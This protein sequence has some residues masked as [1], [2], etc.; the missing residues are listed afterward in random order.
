M[1]DT[2]L[3]PLPKMDRAIGRL[4]GEHTRWAIY[5]HDEKVEGSDDERVKCLN[6]SVKYR[7]KLFAAIEKWATS[8]VLADRREL[9]RECDDADK[10][11]RTIGLDPDACRTDG[12]SLNLPRILRLL[13]RD[14]L[15]DDQRMA[16]IEAWSSKGWGDRLGEI[17]MIARAVEAAVRAYVLADRKA[18]AARTMELADALVAAAARESIESCRGGFDVARAALLE[19]VEG[20]C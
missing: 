14:A 16:C 15:T 13:E 6:R 2:T 5:A 12:G 9:K 19:W 10:L 1:T 8:A 11:L 17:V 20:K 4:L 7:R 18:R 3:P